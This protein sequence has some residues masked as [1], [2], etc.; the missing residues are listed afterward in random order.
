MR[1]EKIADAVKGQAP[2]VGQPVGV[3]ALRPR[4]GVYSKI[5]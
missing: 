2:R 5:A 4:S 1:R 3:S